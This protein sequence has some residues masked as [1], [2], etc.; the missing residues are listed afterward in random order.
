MPGTVPTEVKLSSLLELGP[1]FRVQV[2]GPTTVSSR[3]NLHSH[4]QTD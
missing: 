3:L 4:L 1:G 2:S